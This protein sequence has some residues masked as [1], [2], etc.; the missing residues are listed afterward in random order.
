M[1]VRRPT[2]IVSQ[3]ASESSPPRPATRAAGET[4]ALVLDEREPVLDSAQDVTDLAMRLRG[5]LMQLGP[6][7]AARTTSNESLHKALAEAQRLAEEEV[8]TD[9]MPARVHLRHF[10]EAVQEV[11]ELSSEEAAGPAST[12]AAPNSSTSQQCHVAGESPEFPNTSN[13]PPC[14]VVE[15]RG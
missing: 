4:V 6:F 14:A 5:H 7:T 11:L 12:H 10:A 2:K 13:C 8:P 15:V 9:F 1:N 3:N